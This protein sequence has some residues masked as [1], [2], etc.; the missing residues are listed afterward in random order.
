MANDEMLI[1]VVR[2][3]GPF[4]LFD[5]DGEQIADDTKSAIMA[6][7]REEAQ[8]QMEAGHD[9]QVVELDDHERVIR[10]MPYYTG[11]QGD[12]EFE[13]D[14][15]PAEDEEEEPGEDE[16]ADPAAAPPKGKAKATK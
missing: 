7:A 14:P 6:L 4:A 1:Y 3:V 13:E 2:K 10:V 12:I 15:D 5:P 11:D 16:E 8:T 9:T